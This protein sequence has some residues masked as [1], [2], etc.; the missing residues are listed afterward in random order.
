MTDEPPALSVPLQSWVMLCPL[1]RFHSTVQ[2]LTA[3]VPAVTVTRPWKP[4][5]QEF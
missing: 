1:L 5:G 2:P 3:D 4:P